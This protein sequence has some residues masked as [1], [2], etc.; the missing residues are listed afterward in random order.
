MRDVLILGK[1]RSFNLGNLLG[2]R[3][4][5]LCLRDTLINRKSKS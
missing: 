5:K 4:N 3:L 2:A 1:P